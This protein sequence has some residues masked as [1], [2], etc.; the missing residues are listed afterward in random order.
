MHNGI[1]TYFDSR[2]DG[3][4]MELLKPFKKQNLIV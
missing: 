4:E 2:R 1:K 3:A